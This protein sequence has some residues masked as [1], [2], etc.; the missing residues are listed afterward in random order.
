M[1]KLGNTETELKKKRFLSV[2]DVV[3]IQVISLTW[4]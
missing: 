2:T 3:L 4:F 1:K